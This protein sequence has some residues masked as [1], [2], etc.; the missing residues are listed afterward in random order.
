MF[1]K[2]FVIM[3]ALVIFI[4]VISSGTRS[5]VN[6]NWKLEKQ[7][8]GCL[9][10]TSEV[11]GKDYIASKCVCL[12]SAKM[13]VVGLILRDITNFPEWMSD[14]SATRM[15]KVVNDQSDS[16]IFWFQQH[17]PLLTDRDMVLR[18]NVNQNYQKGTSIIDIANT[19][20]LSYDAG[21]GYVR[22]P[23]FNSQWLL[24]YVD[25]DTT[26]V[27]FMIDP[28]LGKGVPKSIA[29]SI[30]TD[31]PYKSIM[32]MLKMTKQ[33]KYVEAAKT[34]KYRTM[35]DDAVKKGYLKDKKE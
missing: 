16:F 28:D 31:T 35:I 2:I 13:D 9:I 4:S 23:S 32:G 17:I 1:K 14:C 8:G 33:S 22:M 30:I 21:K 27:T 15:L 6:Y 29:N 12:V 11:P 34:S 10:Y 25:K 20:E 3:M 7:K 26:K 24:E 19:G 18:T 5:G